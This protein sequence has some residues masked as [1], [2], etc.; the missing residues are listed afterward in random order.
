MADSPWVSLPAAYF[1]QE[2]PQTFGT[3]TR[4]YYPKLT[5]CSTKYRGWKTTAAQVL[6]PVV[7]LLLLL[8][9]QYVPSATDDGADQTFFI[10][11]YSLN[12]YIINRWESSRRACTTTQLPCMFYFFI[13][14]F[15]NLFVICIGKE[16]AEYRLLSAF[17]L[18]Q[19]LGHSHI[20]NASAGTEE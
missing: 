16:P 14:I 13:L 9:I 18:A 8:I 7:F 6:A 2:E 17:L 19:Q 3:T 20:D 1:T 15:A 12:R 5:L 11:I 4:F 10:V